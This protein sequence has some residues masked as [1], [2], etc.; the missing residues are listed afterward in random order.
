MSHA[1]VACADEL[2]G[3]SL[4]LAVGRALG[5]SVPLLRVSMSSVGK[6][7]ERIHEQ[8]KHSR[9]RAT[10]TGAS[11][12]EL[13]CRADSIRRHA[14]PRQRLLDELV[15]RGAAADVARTA[16]ER[17][18]AIPELDVHSEPA[19]RFST[20]EVPFLRALLDDEGVTLEA[21]VAAGLALDL[22]SAEVLKRSVLRLYESPREED[23]LL[24]SAWRTRMAPAELHAA[25]FAAACEFARATHDPA[26]L[27][28]LRDALQRLA[29]DTTTAE[30]M[31]ALR[32]YVLRQAAGADSPA[33]LLAG[34]KPEP[35]E[36]FDRVAILAV[37]RRRATR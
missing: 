37:R 19:W 1:L 8:T 29:G 21:F 9:H 5:E 12:P 24:A 16:V 33:E 25:A 30:R 31:L 13:A 23:R 35:L 17:V 15:R 20:R 2:A 14:A 10:T 36:G 28:A 26:E 27:G 7:D 11:L 4:A 34:A 18:M 3:I 32:E 22:S 6:L